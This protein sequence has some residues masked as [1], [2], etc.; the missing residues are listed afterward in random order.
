MQSAAFQKFEA[1][2]PGQAIVNGM[3]FWRRAPCRRVL[4]NAARLLGAQ[5][6]HQNV[7]RCKTH[8]Q[9]AESSSEL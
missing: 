2:K 8:S 9:N 4:E 5:D 6:A 7:A 3:V 1:Q